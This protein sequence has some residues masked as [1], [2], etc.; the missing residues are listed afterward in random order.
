MLVVTPC[1]LL[2]DVQIKRDAKALIMAVFA[3]RLPD[4]IFSIFFVASLQKALRQP[5]S[6][7]AFV[8]PIV[9]TQTELLWSIIAASVPCLKTFMRPFDKIDEDTWR[10][11]NDLYASQRSG[12]S[13]RDPKDKDVPL[14]DLRR[15]SPKL[16]VF[17][18]GSANRSVSDRGGVMVGNNV[19]ISHPSNDAASDD[20]RRQSWGSQERI[21]KAQVQW[22]VRHETPTQ[23][24]A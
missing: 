11:N 12:R 21:I 18:A 17:N 23:D 1:L 2:L 14:D 16:G 15:R 3:V 10:S 22:E 20:A 6:G 4:I 13:W 5:D 9:W 24:F 7:L 8:Y 19:T